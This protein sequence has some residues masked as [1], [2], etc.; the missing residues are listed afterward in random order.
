MSISDLGFPAAWPTAS[1]VD[2]T[3]DGQISYGV[4]QPG[5]SCP[6]GIPI[7]RVNN[8]GAESLDISDVL[9][10]SPEIEEK[11][12]RTRLKGG[13]ILLTVVGTAGRVAVAPPTFAGW[14]VARAIAVIRPRHDVGADWLKIWLE[15]TAA[16]AYLDA[17]ANTTVQK[18]LNLKDVRSLPVPLPPDEIRQGILSAILP[19]EN[20]IRILREQNETLEA[21]ARTIFKSWFVDFDPVR[22]K[23]EGREPEGMDA[24]T[25]ALFPSECQ[26]SELG[27]IP[28]R[29]SVGTLSNYVSLNPESWSK[30]T[31]PEQIDYV[32]LANT[33]WGRIEAIT[34]FSREEAPSRA[35]RVLRTGDTIIG[36]VRPG[37]GSYALISK[38]GLTG[39]TGFAVLRPKETHLSVFVYLCSTAKDN[40]EVLAN[41]AD[42]GA[43]PAVRP[44][45]VSSKRIVHPPDAIQRQFSE[46][47][48]SLMQ[49]IAR[50]EEESAS[51]AELRD[52]LL[53]RLISGRLRVLE[54]EAMLAEAL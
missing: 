17:R 52:T 42:G 3:E 25:A 46:V 50:H 48:T 22:A 8:I 38:D 40:I 7:V 32:D 12:Q 34:P 14:N 15:S 5:Q 35:Q 6:D 36:T 37:N 21:M 24:T 54:A 9:R 4:V 43:Y 18:T 45:V 31:R 10:I 16:Q 1:L 23:A 13:E 28:Q 33:K 47:V 51:L 27:P 26:D 29:W 41:L 19:L 2:C 39:S 30:S 20:R 49:A 44:E 53:P 11:Y